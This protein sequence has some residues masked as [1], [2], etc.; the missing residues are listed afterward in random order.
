MLAAGLLGLVLA[1][2]LQSL[3]LLVAGAACAG[4]GHGLCFLDAQQELNELAPVERRGE[5]T[6]AFIAA[7]YFLVASSVIATGL[8]DVWI[9]L[10]AS[11]AVVSVA[12]MAAAVGSSAWHARL[13]FGT[14]LPQRRSGSSSLLRRSRPARP[15]SPSPRSSSRGRPARSR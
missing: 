5:V 7:I 11:V 12:L 13:A 6:A 14:W 3:A 15:R 4:A 8:L 10:A 9:S 1:S 2:P